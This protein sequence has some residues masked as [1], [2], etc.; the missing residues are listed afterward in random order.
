MNHTV[1]VMLPSGLF[2]IEYTD[3]LEAQI[4]ARYFIPDEYVIS[5]EMV[6][7][8]IEQELRSAIAKVDNEQ[9]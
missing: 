2:E 3:E 6:K 1:H 7:S 5:V 9:G 4:R 8:F